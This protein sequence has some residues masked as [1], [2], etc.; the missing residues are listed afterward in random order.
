MGLLTEIIRLL[1]VAVV[2]FGLY[3]VGVLVG[4]EDD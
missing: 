4:T 1:S 2:V 3:V